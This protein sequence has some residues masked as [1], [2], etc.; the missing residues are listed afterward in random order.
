MSFDRFVKEESSLWVELERTTRSNRSHL[1]RQSLSN[2]FAFGNLY[3]R[4]LDDLSVLLRDQPN[5][6]GTEQLKQVVSKAHGAVYENVSR[7]ES[8]KELVT[9]RVW[10]SIN[11]AREILGFVVL[12][13]AVVVV[14]GVMWV[15]LDPTSA[16]SYV[17]IGSSKALGGSSYKG[18]FFG[19]PVTYKFDLSVEIFVHNIEV[20]FILFAG[21]ALLGVPTVIVLIINALNLGLIGAIFFKAGEGG[22]FLRLVLPHGGLE[23]SAI[24]VAGVCGIR[25]AK[26]IA[27][28]TKFPRSYE[29]SLIRDPIV[30]SIGV[31]FFTLIIA[32]IVEGLV[33]TNFFNLAISIS[34]SLSL[35]ILFWLSVFIFGR[36]KRSDRFI[37]LTQ[38]S[39]AA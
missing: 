16:Y 26:A 5:S 8:F 9:F 18:A 25:I 7:K 23:L 30:D 35:V 15:Y 19:F 27:V 17:G 37:E 22:I 29:L 3:R 11:S 1:F 12:L 32:G 36:V 4:S 33:T 28:P 10:R 24:T 39:S 2:I 13:E 34:I 38:A 14:L 20:S 6:L 21:G 31:C